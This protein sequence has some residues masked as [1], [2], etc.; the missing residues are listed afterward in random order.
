MDQFV[1]QTPGIDSFQSEDGDEK[2]TFCYSGGSMSQICNSI[3]KFFFSKSGYP[4]RL[5][6][7]SGPVFG[8]DSGSSIHFGLNLGQQTG[9]SLENG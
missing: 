8:V 7:F 3:A 5:R 4:S 1:L 6:P 2:F 9:S